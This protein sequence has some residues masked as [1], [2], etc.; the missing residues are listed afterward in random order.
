MGRSLLANPWRV[1]PSRRRGLTDRPR[2]RR[3][4]SPPVLAVRDCCPI[5]R[6]C[7]KAT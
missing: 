6:A 2:R 5:I 3:P 1:L 4:A 7:P